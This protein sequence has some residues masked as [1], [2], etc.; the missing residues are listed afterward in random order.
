MARILIVETDTNL[1]GIYATALEG[2]GHE[3]VTAPHV[4]D[5]AALNRAH[6][7]DL[8][9]MDPAEEP[10]SLELAE[11]LS[12]ASPAVHLIFN[13]RDFYGAVR[14]FST[15]VADALAEKSADLSPLRRA[16]RTLAGDLPHG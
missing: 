8:I 12:R 9:V 14:D 1:R 10:G 15:W 7:P 3:V 5:A 13:T 4:H 2:D 16:V 6:H 11:A